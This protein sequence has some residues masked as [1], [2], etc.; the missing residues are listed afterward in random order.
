MKKLK[1]LLNVFKKPKFE[2][3]DTTPDQFNAWFNKQIG[4]KL[5]GGDT[6]YTIGIKGQVAIPR[7][8]DDFVLYGEMRD[9]VDR[10]NSLQSQNRSIKLEIRKVRMFYSVL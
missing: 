5:R 6:Y 7:V 1:D 8:G 10:L 9:V 2:S 3:V 4:K